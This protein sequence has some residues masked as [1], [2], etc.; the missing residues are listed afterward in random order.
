MGLVKKWTTT[1]V[2]VT[3]DQRKSYCEVTSPIY[4]TSSLDSDC[5]SGVCIRYQSRRFELPNRIKYQGSSLFLWSWYYCSASL[6]ALTHPSLVP[7]SMFYFSWKRRS[8]HST[9][10]I[11]ISPPNHHFDASNHYQNGGMAQSN[12]NIESPARLSG[13]PS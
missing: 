12:V 9:S 6:F 2:L 4:R 11:A 3:F 5:F 7:L 8:I 10:E 13:L 1:T